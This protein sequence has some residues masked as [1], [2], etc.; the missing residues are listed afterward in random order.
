M[1]VGSPPCTA[2]SV[3]RNVNLHKFCDNES[4]L[5]AFDKKLKHEA[6]E[7]FKI[8]IHLYKMQIQAGRYF[9][10]KHPEGA[11]SWDLEMVKQIENL[12]VVHKVGCD[13]CQYGLTTSVMGENRPARKP[14]SFMTNS[15]FVPNELTLKCPGDHEHFNIMEGRAKAADE[16]PDK[17]CR[18]VR[19]G[20]RKQ[21]AFD[22]TGLCSLL[23]LSN[24]D[25]QKAMLNA[26]M[27]AHWKDEQHEDVMEEE[28][29][30]REIYVLRVKDGEAWARDDVSG[31]ELDPLKVRKASETEMSYFKNMVV[32]KKVDR[33]MSRGK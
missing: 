28:L 1:I 31:V 6:V 25:Q 8:C 21:Q 12:A 33:S 11:T 9:T 15:L 2:F 13:Q 16:Y 7:H 30:R 32:Y 3:S 22:K 24:Q 27:L 14:T 19:R 26:G 29:L 4:W 18:A 20:M 5:S 23:S 17:L 10:H